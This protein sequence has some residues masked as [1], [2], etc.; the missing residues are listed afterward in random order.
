MVFGAVWGLLL[1]ALPA[2]FAFENPFAVSPFLVAAHLCA[3]AAGAAGALLTGYVAGDS[4]GGLAATLGSGALFGLAAA[5]MAALCV[6]AA[7]TVNISGF[8]TEDVGEI[9]KFLD[10]FRQ[11]GLWVQSSVAALAVFVYAL[12]AGLALA[13]VSGLIIFRINRPDSGH[14]GV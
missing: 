10:V 8:S 13:P 3:A 5:L 11:P 9:A 1:T 12:A 7:L 2:V 4:P 14:R 6:W